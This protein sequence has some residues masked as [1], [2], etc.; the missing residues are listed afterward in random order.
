MKTLLELFLTFCKIG[1]TTFGGGYAMLPI[2]QREIVDNKKWAT[3]EEIMDYYAVGQ[4][5][6]GV[7]AVN[8]ATFIGNKIGGIAG[9]ITATIG[10]IFPPVIIITVIAAL[11]NNFASYPVVINALSGIKIAVCALIFNAVYKLFKSSVKDIAGIIL[12]ALTL[13]IGLYSSWSPIFFVLAGAVIG[14]ALKFSAVR[15]NKK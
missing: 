3:N 13:L 5:T 1:A 10:V 9:G 15:G 6:P 8:T 12:F 11:L 14:I 4:C 7:I 2:I